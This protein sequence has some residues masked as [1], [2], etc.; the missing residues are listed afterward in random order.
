VTVN[1]VGFT[2]ATIVRVNFVNRPTTYVNQNQVMGTIFPSDL[3]IPGPVPITVQ[4]P[5]TVD[6]TPFQ[7][8]LLYPIP[9][10]KQMSP[11]SVTASVELTA[12]P[13]AV[14]ITGTDFSQSPIN[15]LEFAQVQVNGIPVPTIYTSTTQV[16]ALIPPNLVAVPGI[17]QVAVV[18]PNPSLAPSNS[19]PLFVNNP[20]A[21]ISAVDAG[22]ISWNPNS[23]PLDFFNAQVVIS[24]NNFSPGAVAWYTPPCDN[25]GIRRALSTTRNSSTQIVATILV[26]CAGNYSIAVANPQPGGGLSVPAN[27]DVPSVSATTI[28]EKKTGPVLGIK[29]D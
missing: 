19:V 14:N 16:T 4:N 25:L 11:N 17:L 8:S 2:P 24:G 7:L 22:H 18:N 9:V 5:N 13:L 1:G 26:S 3:T 21:T 6:S 20:I 27:I 23:P 12:Q 28:I 15:P 10:I 29:V